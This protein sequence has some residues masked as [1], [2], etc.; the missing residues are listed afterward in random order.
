MELANMLIDAGTKMQEILNTFKEEEKKPRTHIPVIWFDRT[1]TTGLEKLEN[2]TLPLDEAVF[3]I[4]DYVER[5]H[6]AVVAN[7]GVL[8]NKKL[9]NMCKNN[10]IQISSLVA[11]LP[12][13]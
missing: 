12:N 3:E 9:G 10:L 1:I 11:Q 2:K 4:R 6:V 7:I 8:K 13:S 5:L